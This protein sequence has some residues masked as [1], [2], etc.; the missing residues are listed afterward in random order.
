MER[1]CIGKEINLY[2]NRHGSY[3]S[4][5]HS[6]HKP[7]GGPCYHGN[8][9][10]GWQDWVKVVY[11]LIFFVPNLKFLEVTHVNDD[12]MPNIDVGTHVLSILSMKMYF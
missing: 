3:Q 2:L 6:D 7:M 5:L 12:N 4:F 1:S 8:P 9:I 11:R 10:K